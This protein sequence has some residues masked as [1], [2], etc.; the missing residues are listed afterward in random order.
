MVLAS[1]GDG[2]VGVDV[3][4]AEGPARRARENGGEGALLNELKSL[5][6]CFAAPT[7][8]TRITE[9]P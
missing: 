8:P 9:E 1:E 4:S 3:C 6:A 2:L 5:R 7:P